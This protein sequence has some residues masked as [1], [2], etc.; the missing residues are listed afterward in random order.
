MGNHRSATFM[1]PYRDVNGKK[2]IIEKLGKNS[3]HKKNKI[4]IVT[5]KEISKQY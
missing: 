2:L 4:Q 3:E 5:S 1:R